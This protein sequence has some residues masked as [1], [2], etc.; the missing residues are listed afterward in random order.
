M[1]LLRRRAAGELAEL[2]GRPALEIDREVR[3]PPASR[4]SPGGPSTALPADERAMLA[5]YSDGGERR[6]RRARRA[7][8]SS[9]WSCESE[10]A[11]WRRRGL[12][13]VRP[14]DVPR[15]PG[16]AA[17][18]RSRLLG[19]MRDTLP[20]PL[21]E[22]LA[23]AGTEWDAPI[24]GEPIPH[25]RGPGAGGRRPARARPAEAVARALPPSG[26]ALSP[27]SVRRSASDA[28][29]D[30][31]VHGSNNWAV[32]GSHTAARRRLLAN[33]M[34]LGISVPN[35][36]YRLSLVF[37]G[38][39][40]E[41]R[42]TGVTLP[43]VRLRDRGQQRPRR[44]GLHEQ[45][46]RLGRPRP[47]RARPGEA[48][49]PTGRPRA[50]GRLE[51]ETE[52]IEVKG[53]KAETARAS[54][55]RS[56]ARCSTRTTPAAAAR[57]RGWR[58]ARAAS[59]R[60]L[61]RMESAG[62]LDEALAVAPEAGHPEPEPRRGGL[63]RARSAGR[64]SAASRAGSG[65]TAACPRPGP[66]GR[67][68]GTA[69]SSP[70]EYPRVVDPP[71]GRIWT[72]NARV[73]AGEKL[74]ASGRAAA[75]TSAPAQ[76]RS[77]TPCSPRQGDR[78][79]HAARPA[80]RPRALPGAL[81]RSAPPRALTPDAAAKDPPRRGPPSRG[82]WGGHAAVDSVGYRI[83]RAFRARAGGRRLV[84]ALT[85]VA[86]RRP[87]AS[88]GT[89]PARWEGPCGR[90]CHERPAHLLNPRSSPAGTPNCSARSTALT[91]SCTEGR[92]P[93]RRER[94]WGERNTA[95]FRHPLC[96]ARCL[97]RRLLDC[98]GSRL[99]GRRHMPRFQSPRPAP[100]SASPSRPG[101]R[102]K[103]SSTCPAA[104]AAIRSRRT[105][106]RARRLGGSLA[107]ARGVDPD[108]VRAACGRSPASRTASRR[109]P[110]AT[111]CS[112][113]TTRRPPTSPRRSS[114]SSRFDGA[115]PPDPRR[116][117]AR[118]RT[119]TPLRGA[120][121]RSAAPAVYLIGEAAERSPR[122]SRAPVPRAPLRRP[123]ARGRRGRAAPR[124]PATSCC[125][126]PPARPSTS[127][128][129]FEARG[130]HFRA[131]AAARRT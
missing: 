9:T 22:F 129:D 128:P 47:P 75:T 57:S 48:P 60:S 59:T 20:P 105:T 4:S 112:T 13:P 66:T 123:R 21:V 124:G 19:L 82:D 89:S 40:G 51:H 8:R 99:P 38:P 12:A 6:P 14:R 114:R 95:A 65:T 78:G 97:A 126:R 111:A 42:V 55:P 72:A 131:L 127:I 52:T 80:R 27:S 31:A 28:A 45:R 54:S 43:G 79:R 70:R 46:G 49:R 88:T 125:S 74:A 119:S 93:A 37:P 56:G 76:A 7:A 120:G 96:A 92:R 61:V 64:S 71:S 32:A 90:S 107:L 50:R 5:A 18:R 11:P 110:S 1:D 69:G 108:A 16:R 87:N 104:R 118:A 2:F 103:A 30:D 73:V 10:P 113:S 94:T 53:E 102:P 85:A 33:D 63:G 101:T 34:H 98:P 58:C 3:V 83:V 41:R 26:R 68:A 39:D 106:R 84:P 62:N 29:D 35:T 122:R 109:W 116:P 100:P 115:D 121:G 17:A 24:E 36:W 25:A 81:A 130:E 23:P 67:D 91:R 44:L 86:R 15:P 117:R 77:A